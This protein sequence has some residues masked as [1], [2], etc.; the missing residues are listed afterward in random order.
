MKNK[1]FM[2]LLVIS[3]S[4]VIAAPEL[5]L[6]TTIIGPA[7]GPVPYAQQDW[8]VFIGY[9][10]GTNKGFDYTDYSGGD[11]GTFTSPTYS[12]PVLTN[13]TNLVGFTPLIA[14]D[15]NQNKSNDDDKKYQINSLDVYINQGDPTQG[16]VATYQYIGMLSLLNT[17]NGK[18]DYVIPGIDLTSAT[19]LYFVLDFGNNSGTVGDNNDGKENFFLV[20]SN[21]PPIPEPAT[22]FLLG[23]GLLGLAGYGRKKFFKK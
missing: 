18:S 1:K 20:N 13:L 11:E 21:A 2:V 22:M 7:I 16:D 3:I 12:G 19:S 10:A 8:P 23:S 15:I 4:V 6:P 5:A 17:G 9:S 14:I